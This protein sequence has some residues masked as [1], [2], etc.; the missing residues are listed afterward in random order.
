MEI[1][2][3]RG[4]APAGGRRQRNSRGIPGCHA[5]STKTTLV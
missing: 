3:F 2:Q 4:R 5:K 1:T